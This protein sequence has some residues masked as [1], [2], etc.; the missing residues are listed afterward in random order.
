MY[1]R[2]FEG[3]YLGNKARCFLLGTYTVG[4][5]SAEWSRDR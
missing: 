1:D 4:T 2:I 3:K 5:S